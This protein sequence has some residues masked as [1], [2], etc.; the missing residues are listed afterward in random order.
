MGLSK[1]VYTNTKAFES[2]GLVISGAMP[3]T[4]IFDFN[5]IGIALAI[6]I[7]IFNRKRKVQ[8]IS[9]EQIANTNEGVSEGRQV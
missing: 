3:S 5:L 4:S 6:V 8:S 1:Y 2:I 9:I 7:V